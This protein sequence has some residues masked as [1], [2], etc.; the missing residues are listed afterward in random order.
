MDAKLPKWIGE[1]QDVEE[2]QRRILGIASQ[3][4][5]SWAKVSIREIEASYGLR[6]LMEEVNQRESLLQAAIGP[7]GD[8]RA[9][10]LIDESS[11]VR[12]V[13]QARH[14]VADNTLVRAAEQ[15]QHL[16]A[17]SAL[18][19]AAESAQDLMTAYES[20]FLLP[21]KDE[22]PQLMGRLQADSAVYSFQRYFDDSAKVEQAM[23]SMRSPWLNAQEAIGSITGFAELQGIGRAIAEIPAYSCLLYTSPSPRDS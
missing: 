6:H 2:Y 3:V 13:E 4:D 1:M 15:V 8:L 19:R 9:L 5:M 21:P 20:R 23:L 11:L 7:L 12:A 22:I 14:L 10:R 18:S 16:M 17:D